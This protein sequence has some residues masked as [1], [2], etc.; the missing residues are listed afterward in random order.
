MLRAIDQVVHFILHL[1]IKIKED[2][3]E[4]DG[5]EV[6]HIHHVDEIFFV[7]FVVGGHLA[8]ELGAAAETMAVGARHSAGDQV[9]GICEDEAQDEVAD[10]HLDEGEEQRNARG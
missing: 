1:P 10:G 4:N 6:E 3:R 7:D 9:E 8:G 2:H 5:D